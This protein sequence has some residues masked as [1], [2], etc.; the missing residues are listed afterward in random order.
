V[1]ISDFF[2]LSNLSYSPIELGVLG[3]PFLQI[4]SHIHIQYYG[5]LDTDTHIDRKFC[6][7]EVSSSTT[8]CWIWLKG[9]FNITQGT[10]TSIQTA[11]NCCSTMNN[12]VPPVSCSI[13]VLK[14]H[15]IFTS[16]ILSYTLLQV[17]WKFSVIKDI[18]ELMIAFT[19][20]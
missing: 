12:F 5:R 17:K 11:I 10:C 2:V 15:A 7:A 4:P 3:R 1:K 16:I 19:W 13:K 6:Y 18:A 20:Y 8:N 9:K 14:F